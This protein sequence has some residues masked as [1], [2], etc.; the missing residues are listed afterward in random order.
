MKTTKFY[1]AMLTGFLL[2]AATLGCH[3][4]SSA[5]DDDSGYVTLAAFTAYQAQVAQQ[6]ASLRTQVV[7]VRAPMAE[8]LTRGI[9][10]I[11]AAPEATTSAGASLG[12]NCGYDAPPPAAT[13]VCVVNSNTGYIVTLPYPGR[14]SNDYGSIYPVYF[15]QAVCQGNAYI[16]NGASGFN[17]APAKG[18]YVLRED[19]F[20]K[21]D[22]DASTYYSLAAGAG[23]INLNALSSS[24]GPGD[25]HSFSGLVPGAFQLT[26]GVANTGWA[27]A[28]VGPLGSAAP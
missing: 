27:A 22:L 1:F 5:A 8:A 2:G 12:T 18:G 14:S 28:P 7:Q 13:K 3:S 16:Q 15:D 17:G 23:S 9:D 25:C 20:N 24:N 21:G 6:F 10:S 19:P 4:S 26:P 11:T